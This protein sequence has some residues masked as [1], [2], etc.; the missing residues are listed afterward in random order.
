MFPA[1]SG[2]YSNCGNCCN[3]RDQNSMFDTMAFIFPSTLF[4]LLRAFAVALVFV[5]IAHAADGQGRRIALVIG[6][7]NYQQSVFPKLQ[8]PPHDAEDMARALRRFGFEVIERKN[9]TLEGMNQAIAEFGSKIGGSEAALFY[10]AGHGI[11]V[12]NQELPD[13]R[14]CRDRKAKPRYP[15]RASISIRSLMKWTTARAA[16]TS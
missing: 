7:G 12:K 15:T 16:P 14:E 3:S 13:P 10:F 4:S 9:Q 2:N 11:R 6:N 8:N 5:S 1:M